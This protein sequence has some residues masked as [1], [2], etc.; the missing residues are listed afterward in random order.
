MWGKE[1]RSEEDV[2]NVFY[3]YLCG[4]PNENGIKVTKTG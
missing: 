2:W 3:L 1:L 4:Q